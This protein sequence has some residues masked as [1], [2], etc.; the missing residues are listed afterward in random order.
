MAGVV[1][2]D[3]DAFTGDTPMQVLLFAHISQNT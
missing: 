2:S 3:P 1:G